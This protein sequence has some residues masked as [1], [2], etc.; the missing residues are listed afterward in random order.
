MNAKEDAEKLFVYVDKS[1]E[2]GLFPED[3][4][5]RKILDSELF[6]FVIIVIIPICIN[7]FYY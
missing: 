1:F 5:T 7:K 4:I 2:S 6:W 3:G